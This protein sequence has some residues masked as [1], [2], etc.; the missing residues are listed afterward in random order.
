MYLIDSDVI[1]LLKKCAERIHDFNSLIIV[2]DNVVETERARD[3][4]AVHRTEE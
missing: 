4:S 3:S 1:A 2:K